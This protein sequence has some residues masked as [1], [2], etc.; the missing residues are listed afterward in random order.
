LTPEKSST[1]AER[2]DG[3]LKLP[4]NGLSDFRVAGVTFKPPER[5]EIVCIQMVPPK[6]DFVKRRSGW[7]PP[8]ALNSA[9]LLRFHPGAKSLCS[10]VVRRVP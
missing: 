9:L 5:R 7:R 10:V 6:V 1:E 2:L 4:G 8:S 3:C